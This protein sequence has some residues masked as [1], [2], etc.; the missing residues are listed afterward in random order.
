[1]HRGTAETELLYTYIYYH[2]TT[3][4]Y[5]SLTNRSRSDPLRSGDTFFKDG[6]AMSKEDKIKQLIEKW[7]SWGIISY[8]ESCEL[9]SEPHLLHPLREKIIHLLH[10]N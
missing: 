10:Q 9:N 6:V 7:I 2:L 5:Y 8:E 3:T 4:S 1:M